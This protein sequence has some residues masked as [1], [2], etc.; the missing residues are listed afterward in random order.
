[1]NPLILCTKLSHLDP[2][3]YYAIINHLL[4]VGADPFLKDFEGWTA[5]EEAVNLTSVKI[6]SILFDYMT[7]YKMKKIFNQ[8]Q[9]FNTKLKEVPDCL[10][11]IK[12]EFD[13]SVIPLVSKF[14]PSDTFRI[15]KYKNHIRLDSTLAGYKRLKSKRRNMS[16][17]YNPTNHFM[18]K[19]KI[20]S[21]E[22]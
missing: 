21:L 11:E 19:H 9:T 18:S 6:S 3:Q 16:V 13:S 14:A 4:E 12:W 20:N 8:I 1:M 17:I 15:W 22:G 10:I 2:A 7:A 5:F